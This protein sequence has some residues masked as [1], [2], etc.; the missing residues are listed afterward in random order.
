M[1]TIRHRRSR[2][3]PNRDENYVL[4]VYAVEGVRHLTLFRKAKGQSLAVPY[5]AQLRGIGTEL[6]TLHLRSNRFPLKENFP[7]YD[8]DYYTIYSS[9]NKE[10]PE[11]ALYLGV[12]L[13][14]AQAGYF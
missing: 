2:P 11:Q 12:D 8:I 14:F 10:S 5:P 13:H 4:P 3:I 6:A 7:F 1:E 9:A